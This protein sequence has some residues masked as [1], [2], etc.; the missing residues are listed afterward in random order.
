M[1]TLSKARINGCITKNRYP[2][3]EYSEMVGR[4]EYLH[5]AVRL[6]TYYCVFCGGYHLTKKYVIQN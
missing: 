6:R 5:R 3:R 1:K 4:I 2:S